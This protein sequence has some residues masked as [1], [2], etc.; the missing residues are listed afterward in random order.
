MSTC[1]FRTGT[2][3][4]V[5]MGSIF[6]TGDCLETP[7]QANDVILPSLP[8]MDFCGA[9]AIAPYIQHTREAS[10]KLRFHMGDGNG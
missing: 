4:G 9:S 10:I 3:Q 1:A 7:Q 2:V 6:L 5:K 8:A